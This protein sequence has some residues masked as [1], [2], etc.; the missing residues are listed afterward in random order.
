MIAGFQPNELFLPDHVSY[1]FTVSFMDG[2]VSMATCETFIR[3]ARAGGREA[4]SC[5]LT[6]DCITAGKHNQRYNYF[7]ITIAENV[8]MP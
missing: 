5:H 7:N 4:M 2:I 6:V 3:S 1:S 8:A